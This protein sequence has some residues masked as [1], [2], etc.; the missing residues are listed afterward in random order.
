MLLF[1]IDV[2]RYSTSHLFNGSGYLRWTEW[3]GRETRDGVRGW[4]ERKGREG[5]Q[6][7]NYSWGEDEG[8]GGE[9]EVAAAD[10]LVES[11]LPP[12]S[13]SAVTISSSKE[14]LTAI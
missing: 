14:L 7:K 12:P 2:N 3:D 11:C 1:L 6:D 4:K 8:G 9:R 13:W 10:D 5:G